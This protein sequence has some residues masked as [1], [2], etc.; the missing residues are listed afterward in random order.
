MR[1]VGVGSIGMASC[2]LTLTLL[3]EATMEPHDAPS[4]WG[5]T[6]VGPEGVAERGVD[7]GSVLEVT[8]TG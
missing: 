5:P 2:A 6:G 4:G 7:E 3:L 8:T 1:F